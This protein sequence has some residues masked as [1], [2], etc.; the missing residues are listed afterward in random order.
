M[1]FLNELAVLREVME[2][3]AKSKKTTGNP[4][5]DL[6]CEIVADFS[7]PEDTSTAINDML[8]EIVKK[9]KE[10]LWIYPRQENCAKLAVPKVNP[11]ISNGL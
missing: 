4:H 8:T 11:E 7:N 6:P 2:P 3:A 9:L 1:I 10:K 5:S